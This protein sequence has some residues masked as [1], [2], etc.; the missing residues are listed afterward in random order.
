VDE[1]LLNRAITL[2]VN[3]DREQTRR[4][5]AATRGTHHRRHLFRRKRAKLVR[6]HATRNASC[7]GRSGEQHDV[8][9]FPTT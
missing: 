4:F 1:E 7:V 5:I 8:G 6:L 9:E 3:E 2:T